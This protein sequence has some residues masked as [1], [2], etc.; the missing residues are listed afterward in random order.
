MFRCR[1]LGTELGREVL[2]QIPPREATQEDEGAAGTGVDKTAGQ[3]GRSL[4]TE[5]IKDL[6]YQNCEQPR[7]D[8]VAYRRA[9]LEHVDPGSLT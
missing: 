5:G 4:D 7:W 2:G 3:R 6:L 1:S 9:G 8:R